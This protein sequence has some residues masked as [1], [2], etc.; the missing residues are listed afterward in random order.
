MGLDLRA[1]GPERYDEDGRR[2]RLGEAVRLGAA[3]PDWEEEDA[4]RNPDGAAYE[5]P[6]RSGAGGW[7]RGGFALLALAGFAGVLW[8]AYEW[9]LGGGEA[10]ELPVVRAEP[11]PEKV[12]PSEPG[13]LEVPYQDQ[14]VMNRDAESVEAPRVERLLPPPEVPLAPLSAETAAAET[15]P[16]A[17]A[18]AAAGAVE[19]AEVPEIAGVPEASSVPVEPAAGPEESAGGQETADL[20]MPQAKPEP[21]AQT[22][23]TQPASNQAAKSQ[24]AEPAATESAAAQQQAAAGGGFALQ[25]AS[26]KDPAAAQREWA[27]IKGQYPALLKDLTLILEPAR[28]EGVGRV[29]RLQTGPFSTRTAAADVCAQLKTKQQDCFIVRR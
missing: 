3:D 8:Y 20:P 27:R 13:G 26:L 1:P 29:Y 17:G 19:V 14:L 2:T 16:A 9:G 23:E 10:V 11:G 18:E 28:I 22:A 5:T 25:L 21:P 24:A 4:S 12:K 7:L 15:L 6:R